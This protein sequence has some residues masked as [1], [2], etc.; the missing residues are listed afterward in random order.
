MKNIEK[1]DQALVGASVV[2]FLIAAFF[3][4]REDSSFFGERGKKLGQIVNF[5]NEVKRKQFGSLAW[6]IINKETDVFVNDQIFT[7][8]DSTAKVKFDNETELDLA[9][10]TLLKVTEGKNGVDLKLLSGF[11]TI[12][13]KDNSQKINLNVGNKKIAIKGKGAKFQ[14]SQVGGESK[15][16]LVEG[17]AEVESGDKKVNMKKGEQVDVAADKFEANKIVISLDKPTGGSTIFFENKSRVKMSWI[18]TEQIPEFEVVVSQK[19]N[20]KGKR[21][22]VKV[23]RNNFVLEGLNPGTYYWQVQGKSRGKTHKSVISQFTL[24][25]S[26]TPELLLPVNGDTLAISP[27]EKD[28]PI[29]LKWSNINVQNYEIE[30]IKKDGSTKVFTTSQDSISLKNIGAGEY[31]WRVRGINPRNPNNLWSGYNQFTVE[32]GS[33]IEVISPEGNKIYNQLAGK[34]QVIFNWDH[35]VATNFKIQISREPEFVQP[36]IEKE[37]ESKKFIW[38]NPRPGKYFWKIT[39]LN[40]PIEGEAQRDLEVYALPYVLTSPLAGTNVVLPAANK[41]IKFRWKIINAY[42]SEGELPAYNFLV[43]VSKDPNFE[44]VI[45]SERTTETSVGLKILEDGKYYW[46]VKENTLGNY[47]VTPKAES[48]QLSKPPFPRAPKIRPSYELAL[49]EGDNNVKIDWERLKYIKNYSLEIFSDESMSNRVYQ[50]KPRSYNHTWNNAQAGDFYYRVSATDTFERTSDY[51]KTGKLSI[52]PPANSL[53]SSNLT[54][55][56][57]GERFPIETTRQIDFSWEQVDGAQG[58]VVQMANDSG[59][60]DIVFDQQVPGDTT[61]LSISDVNNLNVDDYYWRVKTQYPLDRVT[62]SESRKLEIINAPVKKEKEVFE[63]EKPIYNSDFLAMFYTP[64][65]TVYTTTSTDSSI[66]S[67]SSNLLSILLSGQKV[68]KDKYFMK[69]NIAYTKAVEAVTDQDIDL[70]LVGGIF[71]GFSNLFASAAAG[72][73][74]IKTDLL[75]LSD[76]SQNATD[77]TVVTESTTEIA[78]MLEGSIYFGKKFNFFHTLRGKLGLAGINYFSVEY[79]AQMRRKNNW[80]WNFGGNYTSRSFGDATET[81]IDKFTFLI[82][83]SKAL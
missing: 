57:P 59:F 21:K 17:K 78:P 63:D 1:K 79:L 6:S 62:S 16:V 58:Y 50:A 11:F 13:L 70:E 37:L 54:S 77:D 5:T 80:I 35:K 15:L 56:L 47:Y 22:R 52:F 3:F 49:Q 31:N 8:D 82:G 81:D 60:D 67:T 74:F 65:N 55:P 48:F 33:P 53:A 7:N 42:N 10:N 72:I 41:N 34:N 39:T 26:R 51:S 44:N 73:K 2:I 20:L 36:I 4:F 29:Q 40:T 69:S 30:F 38:K 83:I 9:P 23:K 43:E 27:K 25:E 46:R 12:D 61:E 18:T 45:L 71:F 19:I 24:R 28:L 64:S 75:E 14:L 68:I 32:L 66:N 76:T